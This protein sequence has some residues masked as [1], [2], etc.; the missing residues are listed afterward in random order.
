VHGRRNSEFPQN[1]RACTMS[2]LIPDH[3]L[4]AKCI[5][6]A[7]PGEE[8]RPVDRQLGRE[9]HLFPW[10]ESPL[11]FTWRKEVLGIMKGVGY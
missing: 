6:E 8:K 10:P 3:T 7:S 2:M 9:N 4:G 11:S 5:H 1:L